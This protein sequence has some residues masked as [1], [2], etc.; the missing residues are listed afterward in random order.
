V[1]GDNLPEG[2]GGSI[3]RQ[4]FTIRAARAFA[5]VRRAEPRAY[6]GFIL[7]KGV[8]SEAN[9]RVASDL[10]RTPG[11][12]CFK[13]AGRQAQGPA[14]AATGAG[15]VRDVQFFGNRAIIFGFSH[16]C[17]VFMD[18]TF[19]RY[20]FFGR[21]LA[22]GTVR[23]YDNNQ[24]VRFDGN[25]DLYQNTKLTPDSMVMVYDEST[26]G[27]IE[28][29][30]PYRIKFVVDG[31]AVET[32]ETG[33]HVGEFDYTA[34]TL[35][36][37]K[38]YNADGDLVMQVSGLDL[39]M[40][41]VSAMIF[42]NGGWNA[43]NHILGQGHAVFGAD[44]TIPG[45]PDEGDNIETGVGND[46]VFAGKGR[47]WIHDAGGKD[48][49]RGGGGEDT[50][51]YNNHRWAAP[52]ATDGILARLD[53]GYVIG[54]DGIRDQ[55]YSIERI[56]GSMFDD[57][58]IGDSKDNRFEGL[59][60]NDFINGKGGWDLLRF[61]ARDWIGGVAGVKV[62][63]AKGTARDSWGNTDR[64]KNIEGID[65]SEHADVLRDDKNDNWLNGDGGDDKLYFG[66]GTDGAEGG[67]GADTFIFRGDSFGFD[68]ISDFED[69]VDLIMIQNAPDF[70]SLTITP[71]GIDTLV[72]W[73]G[74]EVRLNN[75]TSTD[76]TEDD[77]IF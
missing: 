28:D 34:G 30:L 62:N 22:M 60:G 27:P 20:I 69:G 6:R 76:I 45:E 42:Y 63:M 36:K 14:P 47:D 8:F 18:T 58:M 25:M 17:S 21:Q 51:T 48:V 5:V 10:K 23:Y 43:V 32:I 77:F 65:G 54:S 3:G 73:T 49:Y 74:N 31:G 55:L 1:I 38:L 13:I 9:H 67:A 71:D 12:V 68:R 40:P 15:P 44:L 24:R 66:R 19:H 41:Y 33:P 64:F 72:Q 75:V 37:V 16:D 53:K 52:G 4:E 57:R 56:Q 59:G 11:P 7:R 61:D 35:K 70:G 2:G 29:G 39:S 50:L 46:T 26:H